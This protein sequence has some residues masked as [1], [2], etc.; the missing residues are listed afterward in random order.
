MFSRW[1]PEAYDAWYETP[2]GRL[3]DR[4]EKDLIFSIAGVKGGEKALDLGC[5]TGIYTIELARRGA[6][7]TGV[8]SSKEMLNWAG[9]KASQARQTRKE[10]LAVEFVCAD[11]LTLPFPD[12]CFDL[13][14]SVNLLCFIR[15]REKALLEMRRVLKPGGRLI[16]GVLN[17]WSPWAAFR[18]I[19][20]LFKD[21]V[22]NRVEFISPLELELSLVRAGFNV[23]ELKTCLFFFPIDCRMYLKFAMPFERL[24]GI[25]TPRLGA[26][27]AASAIKPR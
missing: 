4:L 16:V 6:I 3:S 12:D 27:L 25:A 21:T 22:Y 7:A 9:A 14:M 2:L 20:G 19:K 11:A 15:E 18:R 8:D 23:K 26:F 13:I 10:R 5:G 1:N 24:G 17:K